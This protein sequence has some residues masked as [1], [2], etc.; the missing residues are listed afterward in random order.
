MSP[1]HATHVAVASLFMVSGLDSY[2]FKA[3]IS[4]FASRA[5]HVVQI[6]IHTAAVDDRI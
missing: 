2:A 4:T 6:T 5:N 1:L 3:E